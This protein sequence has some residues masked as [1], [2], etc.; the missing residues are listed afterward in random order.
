MSGWRPLQHASDQHGD[1]SPDDRRPYG[2]ADPAVTQPPPTASLGPASLSLG[3]RRPRTVPRGLARSRQVVPES[4]EQV[5]L[6][7]HDWRSLN[8]QRSKSNSPSW[9][10]SAARARDSRD[11][12]VPWRDSQGGGDLLVAEL[13][14]RVQEQHLS[15]V[16]AERRESPGDQRRECGGGYAHVRRIGKLPGAWWLP[17]GSGEP[18]VE[19]EQLLLGP[20]VRAHQIGRDPEE[21]RPQGSE[22]RLVTGTPPVRRGEGLRRQVLGQVGAN[23]P[24]DEPVYLGEVLPKH[25]LEFLGCVNASGYVLTVHE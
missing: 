14:P 17:A 10:R 4:A 18:R 8:V 16:P 25:F 22:R 19:V 2:E 7:S 20:P 15:L 1:D 6:V 21:P 11:R 9:A 3:D 13:R 24:G 5:D 12:A 23:S